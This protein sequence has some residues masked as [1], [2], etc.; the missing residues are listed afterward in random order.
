[1]ILRSVM[2]HVR[3]QNWTA[4]GLDFV[5]VVIGVFMGIQ[6][7]N[8]NDARGDVIRREQLLDRLS[9]DVRDDLAE[10]A[11]VKR[12]AEWRFSAVDAILIGAGVPLARKYPEPNG[13]TMIVEPGQPL[14]PEEP[15][16]A[17]TALFWIA[18]LDG[19]QQAYDTLVSTGDIRLI[20]DPALVEAIQSYY[21]NVDEYHEFES[22]LKRHRN[23]T[24]QTA[25]TFGF[26]AGSVLSFEEIVSL[27]VDHK[28]LAAVL[29]SQ[30]IFDDEQRVRNAALEK[31]GKALLEALEGRQ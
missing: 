18:T 21:A 22:G 29:S 13:G 25:E 23:R 19:S 9:E 12:V 27:V 5:I 26:G 17:I 6:L 3:T 7:G 20:G 24:L 28:P 11:F 14:D 1:M 8:W 2:E 15:L 4:V 30:W 16:Q 10:L 31:K